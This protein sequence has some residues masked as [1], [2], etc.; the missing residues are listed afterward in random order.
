MW[1]E[2]GFDLWEPGEVKSKMATIHPAQ[3]SSALNCG[4]WKS[5]EVSFPTKLGVLI[6]LVIFLRPPECKK[7]HLS[8]V[9]KMHHAQLKS[10]S[11][12]NLYTVHEC[13][14]S[15][16]AASSAPLLSATCRR[17]IHDMIFM[18]Q[19]KWSKELLWPGRFFCPAPVRWLQYLWIHAWPIPG[20]NSWP[21]S[22]CVWCAA[23]MLPELEECCPE[24]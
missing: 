13:S 19:G 4:S 2:V 8:E 15:A 21:G 5:L 22:K 9:V 11:L 1:G 10:N 12:Q 23:W 24:F 14:F 17:S 7:M 18:L 16:L 20:S 3:Y 6:H